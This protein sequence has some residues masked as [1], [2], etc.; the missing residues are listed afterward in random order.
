MAKANLEHVN[1]TVQDPLATAELLVKLFDWRVRWQGDAIHG[2]F[3]VHVGAEDSL[4]HCR[5]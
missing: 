1:I 3:T 2:G 5:S 4:A